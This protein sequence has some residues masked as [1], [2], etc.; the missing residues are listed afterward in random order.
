M[1]KTPRSS[2]SSLSRLA[3]LAAVVAAPLLASG[4][5][6]AGVTLVMQRGN[7][8][9]ST[10]YVDGDKM[11]M[12]N[13]KSTREH[14]V[15]IDAGA[16]KMMMIDDSE[17]TYTEIT[18]ADMERFGEM[19]KGMMKN[20][21][22]EQ[23]KKMM[24]GAGPEEKPPEL[25]FEKTGAKKTINGFSC[26]M[27]RVVEDGK[28]KEEDC[29]APWSA[30]ILTRADF[31][32]LRKFA[33]DMAKSMGNMSA[34]GSKNAFQQFDKYPGFPVSRH[35][36]DPNEH[37]DEVLKSVKRGSIP[38][39]TFTVPAGYTKKDLPMPGMMGGRPRRGPTP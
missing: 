2:G 11:R 19:M 6:Q 15:V 31:A 26:E 32:G 16:K 38:S 10:L 3:V 18:Q 5:A 14:T 33:E 35:P 37:E 27:Y 39:S 8:P 17:K 1:A 24:G 28:P 4:R 36:L 7:D 21:P 29:I 22:P 34:A 13:P 23:R 20:I 25:K 9:T 30:S 12:D